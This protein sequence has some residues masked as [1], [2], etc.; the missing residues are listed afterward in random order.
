MGWYGTETHPEA[1]AFAVVRDGWGIEGL[2]GR[3]LKITVGSRSIFVYVVGA[4]D[5]PADVA[6]TRRAFLGLGLLAQESLPA[7]VEVVE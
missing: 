4:R 3:V 5:V 1:G 2:I 6:V 7:V